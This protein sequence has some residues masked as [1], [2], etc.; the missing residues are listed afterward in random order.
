MRFFFL[1]VYLYCIGLRDRRNRGTSRSTEVVV[2]VPE[3]GLRVD[4]YGGRKL[5]ISFS[6]DSTLISIRN[7]T[8][9]CILLYK[10]MVEYK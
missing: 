8:F 5:F 6:S 3:W 1:F 10:S 7:K 2:M 9:I 4:S